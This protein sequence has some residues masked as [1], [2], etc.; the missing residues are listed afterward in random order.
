M[1][2]P[3]RVYISVDM[4]GITGVI[5]GSQTGGDP[6]EY[7]YYR[8]LMAGDLNAAIEGALEAGV[9]EIV[10]ADSHGTMR[11]LLPE[12][13]NEAA[14]LIRGSPRLLQMM[15]GIDEGFDA[16]FYIGYH[17]MA[18]AE[19]AILAHTIDGGTIDAVYVNGRRTGEFGLNAAL[20]GWYDV[21]SVFVSGD[22]AFCEEALDFAP[23]VST[24]PV[25]WAL[26]RES[27]KCLH[28]KKA[29]KLIKEAAKDSLMKIKEVEPFWFNQPVEVKVRWR[30]PTMADA[31]SILP[32]MERIDGKTTKEEFDDYPTAFRGLRASIYVASAVIRR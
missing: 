4:E 13:I 23:K 21:P 12:D 27:A 24:A 25:K 26:G 28:P 17:A 20:A 1:I 16:A 19:H 2:E 31:V 5:D 14:Y 3:E 18:G 22:L 29:R 30:S 10:V 6:T 8:R 11:N 15:A 32:Y 9:S 7:S